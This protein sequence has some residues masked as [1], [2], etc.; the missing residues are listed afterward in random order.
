MLNKKEKSEILK[1]NTKL[2]HCV[3]RA[4]KESHRLILSSRAFVAKGR[5]EGRLNALRKLVNLLDLPKDF[6]PNRDSIIV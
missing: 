4:R 1:Y 5:A 2:C 3:I 6:L